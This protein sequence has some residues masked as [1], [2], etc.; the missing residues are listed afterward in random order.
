MDWSGVVFVGLFWL[1][2][3]IFCDDLFATSKGV[4]WC[5]SLGE[6]MT[7]S[8]WQSNQNTP[9]SNNQGG[10][11]PSAVRSTLS[12]MYKPRIGKNFGEIQRTAGVLPRLLA[13]IFAMQGLFPSHHP[14]L[15]DETLRLGMVDVLGTAFGSLQWNKQ[16]VPKICFFFAVLATLVFTVIAFAFAVVG[17]FSTPA[18][19]VGYF[20]NSLLNTDIANRWLDYLFQPTVTNNFDVVV[21][22]NAL[23]G[24]A[25]QSIGNA[26]P[27]AFRRMAGLY[28]SAMLILAVIILL[29]H[30]ISMLVHTAHDG[31]P[32]GRSAHQIW[33]PVRLVFALGLLIPL[34]NG[35]SSGQWLVLSI[36]KLGSNLASNVWSDPTWGIGAA[37]TGQSQQLSTRPDTE[38]EAMINNL[39]SI[40]FCAK[41]TQLKGTAVQDMNGFLGNTVLATRTAVD[42]ARVADINNAL[43]WSMN[44][45]GAPLAAQG[46]DGGA[47]AAAVLARRNPVASGAGTSTSAGAVSKSYYPVAPETPSTGGGTYASTWTEVPCGT[48]TFPTLAL[49]GGV[50]P[51]LAPILQG[52]ADS[53]KDAF[54]AIE[55]DALSVGATLAASAAQ[56]GGIGSACLATYGSGIPAGSCNASVAGSGA[57]VNVAQSKIQLRQDYLTAFQAALAGNAPAVTFNPATGMITYNNIPTAAAAAS[58]MGTAAAQNLGWMSAAGWFSSLASKHSIFGRA[59]KIVPTVNADCKKVD[60]GDQIIAAQIEQDEKGFISSLI[61]SIE[62][63]VVGIMDAAKNI[64]M[65]VLRQIGLANNQN[66]FIWHTMFTSDSPVSDMIGLGNIL[67]DGGIHLIEVGVVVSLIGA[68]GL[69]MDNAGNLTE[70]ASG[71]TSSLTRATAGVMGKAASGLL[72]LLPSG[73]LLKMVTGGAHY[74]SLVT[75]LLFGLASMIIVPGVFLFYILPFLPFMNFVTG[76]ITWLISLLQAVV[77]I[78]IIAIAHISP[79]GEGLP[80]S[81]ARGAYTMIL[82]IF[83]RPIMMIFGMLATIMIMNTGIAFL[84]TVFF[85]IYKQNMGGN[86]D[87]LFSD[88]IF[89]V[90]YA[91]AAW[92][93]V[94]AAVT[95]ID[96]FPL[97]AVTWIGGGQGVDRNHDV[98]NF[99]MLAAGAATT[100]AVRG[101]TGAAQNVSAYPKE[102]IRGEV[103][104]NNQARAV[105]NAGNTGGQMPPRPD[106]P[107]PAPSGG[108]GGGGGGSAS[109]STPNQP[110]LPGPGGNAGNAGGQMPPRPD[111]PAPKLP[112]GNGGN[113]LATAGGGSQ[114]P[115][116]TS[117]M[118]PADSFKG[119][120][121]PNV[122]D[123]A[124]DGSLYMGGK[125]LGGNP[126]TQ[127]AGRVNPAA[128][129]AIRSA[130]KVRAGSAAWVMQQ[131]GNEL[132]GAAAKH[133]VSSAFLA[134]Q[135][136][137]ESGSKGSAAVSAVGARGSAQ[138]MPA[139]AKQYGI[140]DFNNE[141]QMANAQ[142]HYMADLKKMYHGDMTKATAA[143][144]WGQGNVNKAIARHGENWLAHA[145]AETQNYVQKIDSRMQSDFG[146]SLAAIGGSSPSVA[147][148]APSGIAP[149]SAEASSSG[150]G[151]TASTVAHTVLGVASFIPGVSVISG[152]LDAALYTAEGDYGNAAL[153]AAAM[154]PGG[155]WVT[156]GGKLAYRG[157]QLARGA[158][159]LARAEKLSNIV[160]GGSDSAGSSGG[161]RQ[162]P[163]EVFDPYSELLSAAALNHIMKGK[164]KDQAKA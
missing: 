7:V 23:N 9:K 128:G 51:A 15:R 56:P 148:V 88:V 42:A 157:A 74:A 21:P 98:S 141:T 36:A 47:I 27:I 89:M 45:A 13:G 70:N 138:F 117:R 58:L 154:I 1:I 146:T 142:A 30:L 82:Q 96:D 26:V 121:D 109:L 91:G 12:Y 92:G 118:S 71:Q 40:G 133:N 132:S 114:P 131:R 120:N 127:A 86:A 152:G 101:V 5:S 66:N 153:S 73:K 145:P 140:T 14:A 39:I 112:S 75:P 54:A 130:G 126:F 29:Y 48:V 115:G 18:H 144:N 100:G 160:S 103:R 37:V 63:G 156:T 41:S 113:Q 134:A 99:A 19:A 102:A 17:F 164:Q 11:K 35:F 155:K 105:G 61:E 151:G 107:A 129:S 80:S 93:I 68:L 161:A 20:D 116:S 108:G 147:A 149:Q 158:G 78:P 87:G 81:S 32:M 64:G 6:H 79:N 59:A 162:A 77:A 24:T 53:H 2:K 94:N 139:T 55:H 97:K 104:D 124:A 57:G 119:R 137:A 31:T 65:G 76:V 110:R 83:L 3:S 50:D 46:A 159:K 90:M 38:A 136:S 72:K 106:G 150:G 49:D 8:A 34:S 33:A 62:N 95:A 60:C 52:I 67:V 122:I 25:T 16:G 28:S 123:Q 10:K 135:Q 85:N 43:Y 125:P 69:A 4:L 111:G 22:N 143:Y 163:A 84:N 44:S